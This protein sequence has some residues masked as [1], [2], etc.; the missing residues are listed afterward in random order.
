ML[1]EVNP[2][3]YCHLMGRYSGLYSDEADPMNKV[4]GVAW[5]IL[6]KSCWWSNWTKRSG[7][8]FRIKK[9]AGEISTYK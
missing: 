3:Q 7:E 9:L 2:K 1:T 5:L 6:T 4:G 8:Q